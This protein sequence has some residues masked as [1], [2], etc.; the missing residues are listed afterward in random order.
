MLIVLD[1]MWK[2]PRSLFHEISEH[3]GY[4]EYV[5]RCITGLPA[6]ITEDVLIRLHH[7]HADTGSSQLEWWRTHNPT[8]A[9]DD[10]LSKMR[11]LIRNSRLVVA[12][13]NG[14]T[15]LETLNLNIPTLITWD[16][17]YVQLRPEA[18]TYFQ[19]L[20]EA[21]IFHSSNHSFA[22]HVTRHWNNIESWWASDTVQSARL[23]FCN[24]FSRID[25]H[26]LLFLRKTLRTV[27]TTKFP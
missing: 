4:L 9:V 14:T 3:D 18:F 21:G 8:V 22:D 5:T 15:F 6:K 26:P 16:S 12:T 2:H 20:E 1:H 17:S 24:E 7:A 19:R 23:L 27:K 25:P 10:G 13:S 11:G